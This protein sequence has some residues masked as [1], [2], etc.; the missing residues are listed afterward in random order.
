MCS[1][2]LPIC[3]AVCC[4]HRADQVE[5][6]SNNEI[7]STKVDTLMALLLP[8]VL[9]VW[10]IRIVDDSIFYIPVCHKEWRPDINS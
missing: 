8:K 10:N 4:G 5:I 3:R 9:T 7:K 2:L 6:G 1:K